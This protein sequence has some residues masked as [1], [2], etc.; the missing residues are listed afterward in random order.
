MSTSAIV[1]TAVDS[2]ILVDVLTNDP[3]YG[4]TSLRALRSAAAVGALI[5]CPIVWGE[6]R[7]LF[8]DSAVME[9]AF[10]EA[11]IGFDP[12]DRACA[13]VAGSSWREYRRR[14]GSRTRM[15]ADFFI[16]A[17]AKARGGRLITR[18]RGF[19]RR[20]FADLELVG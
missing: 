14:G 13:D 1:V 11:K 8:D 6:V 15:I 20:Y 3:T 7:G 12:F 4:P 10:A 17:H 16:A 5:V 18:D 9:Q 19:Y 2:S